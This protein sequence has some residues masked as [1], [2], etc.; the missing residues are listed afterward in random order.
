MMLIKLIN[1]I[2]ER[3]FKNFNKREFLEEI[4][5]INIDDVLYL[6]INDLSNENFYNNIN[7]ILDEFAPF[8]KLNI[9]DIKLTTK[10]W[11]NKEVQHLMWERDKLFKK[12]RNGSDDE[13]K[14]KLY[15]DYKKIRNELTSLKRNNKQDY[16]KN[17]FEKNK[18]KTAA[19]CKGIRSLV[20]IKSTNKT[21]ISILDSNGKLI[22]NPLKIVNCFNEYFVNV[23]CNVEN[24][25]P[26]RNISYTHYLKQIR[27]NKSFYLGPATSQYY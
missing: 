10:P 1:N 24:K 9:N 13:A 15:N 23:G 17:Y 2:K 25:I 21:D 16:Y 6:S 19:L 14:T 4:Q 18:K 8:K 26:H 7:Y 27:I 5:N 22:T 12:F 11:I 20:T 3:N